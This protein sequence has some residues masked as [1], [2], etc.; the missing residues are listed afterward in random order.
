MPFLE[1][2]LQPSVSRVSIFSSQIKKNCFLYCQEQIPI[3][4]VPFKLHKLVSSLYTRKAILMSQININCPVS[5]MSLFSIT[6][7]A[8]TIKCVCLQIK[9]F[10]FLHTPCTRLS[11]V[12]ALKT[13]LL[14]WTEI[15][16]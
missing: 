12:A 10:Q 7:N 8:L 16:S 1:I 13:S 2:Y 3:R 9:S 14:I 5:E 15:F 6:M 11:R 4:L